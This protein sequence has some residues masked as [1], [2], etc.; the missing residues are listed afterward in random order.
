M[1]R[2]ELTDVFNLECTELDKNGNRIL[3]GSSTDLI[4]WIAG[5]FCKSSVNKAVPPFS[6]AFTG[7][8]DKLGK[9]I[10][11]GDKIKLYYKGEYVI[12]QVIYDVKHAAFFIKWPDGYINQYFMNGSSYEVVDDSKTEIS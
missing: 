11:E 8:T 3:K 10:H 6:K 2:E 7:M 9:P 1:T 5:K 4:D 12:C